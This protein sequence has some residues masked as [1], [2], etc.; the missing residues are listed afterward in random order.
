MKRAIITLIICALMCNLSAQTE[1][2]ITY[3]G[4][5]GFLIKIGDKKI[6][7]D[8]LFKGFEDSYLLPQAVQDKLTSAQAPFDDVDLVLVTHA[9]GDHIDADMV[10]QHLKN[11]PNAIF[12]S[13]KQTVDALNARD[14]LDNFHER[15]IGFNPSKE[16]SDI[17]DINGISIE[18]FYLP[19]GSDSRIINNGFLISVNGVSFFHTGD[20]DFDQFTF[21]EF[22]SLQLPE[23]K[24]DLSFIQHFYLT[25]DSTSSQFVNKGIGGK[26]ILP[27]HYHFTT[28]GFDAA[29]IKENYPDAIL[30]DKELES[31][32]MPAKGNGFTTQKG[33]YF[34]QV[35]PGDS[36]LVY[37][38]GIFSLPNRLES[39]ITFSPDGQ[40]CYFGLLEIKDKKVSYKV[41]YTKYLNNKWTEQKEAAF[42]INNNYS[43]PVFSADGKKL[44]L[45]KDGNIWVL[46]RSLDGWGNP[47]KLPAPINSEAYEGSFTESANG[48]TYISSR[49]PNGYGGIDIWRINH[50]ADQSLQAENLGPIMNSKYFDY[51]PFIAPDGSYLIFGSYRGRADGLLYIS[52][53]KGNGEWTTPINMNSCGAKI[54]NTTA[55]HSNP[56]LSP[57]GKFLFFR[58]HANMMEMDVYWV[59]TNILKKLREKAMIE[60]S[61]QK[62]TNPKG[63]YLGQ[64]PPGDMPV[65]FAPGIVSVN[66]RLEFSVSFSP[67]LE[68][69]YFTGKRKGESSS[70]YFSKLV[71]NKWTNPQKANLTKGGEMDE[72][73]A[74]V[75]H[76]GKRIYFTASD[77][78]GVEIW[79]A[80]R[81]GDWWTNAKKLDSPINDDMAFYPNEAENGDLFYKN[82]SKGKMYYA[83]NRDGRFPEIFEAG[84]EYGS[85]GFIAPSQDFMLIDAL[86]ENDKTKD[87]DIHVCFKKEDGAWT[88]PINLGSTINSNFNETCPSISPDGKYL[89]FSRYNEEGG[90]PNIYWVSAKI[91]DDLKTQFLADISLK[92]ELFSAVDTDDLARVRALIESN[93]SLLEAKDRAGSTPLIRA[94]LNFQTFG[95]QV[96]V[97][98]FLIE[99]GADVNVINNYQANALLRASV[100][101]GPDYDLIKLLVSK[102]ADVNVQGYNGITALHWAV[103]YNDLKT[104]KFLLKSGANINISNDYNGPISTST[105]SGT[106]L[107]VAINY[108]QSNEMV[109]L[110]IENGAKLSIKDSQG[111]TELHLAALKGN[112]EQAK[113]LIGHGIDLNAKNNFNRTALYYAA[114]HGHRGVAELL[115]AAGADKSTILETNYGKAKQLSESLEEGE[116]YIWDLNFSYAV[117]TK[118]NLLVFT[119]GGIIGDSSESGLA[120]GFLNADELNDQKITVFLR[121]R[122]SWP[123][124]GKR[125]TELAKLTS[126]VKMVSSIKPD[127]SKMEE[128]EIPAYR[129][130]SPNENFSVDGIKVHT[131]PALASGMGYLVELD[132]L[133]IFHAG[134]HISDDDPEHI[135]KFRKE[136][137]FLKAFGPVDIVMLSTHSHSNDVGTGYEQYLYLLDKLAPKAIYLWGANVPEQYVQCAEFLKV[138]N[139]P[140]KYPETSKAAGERFHYQGDKGQK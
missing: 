109:K 12:A 49:R 59:S 72:M 110:I 70:I 129:F 15:R 22:R 123:M 79:T 52:F 3:V 37:A 140:I 42:S 138:R 127:F 107:Q 96:E 77:S 111:N 86:K 21:E 89:F 84:I 115:I 136:I 92:E 60:A 98:K 38:P 45:N 137:D 124:D 76:S 114:K 9:H 119:L 113:I 135:E 118:N 8:A 93:P 97:A 47:K 102:G 104:A 35:L 41:Y 106:V 25:S 61:P 17:K 54:N 94:C 46:E 2:E 130:A 26:Y 128:S 51:C 24:I 5:S 81:S 31:W 87:K 7:I 67:D 57:D 99:A 88:K 1:T 69:I 40:E 4:N 83:P 39:N 103:K 100:G 32:K 19:H 121:H 30:F 34:N 91:I 108:S 13:T 78:M 80:T 28:P 133:K 139:I 75:N 101:R 122:G 20:V 73:E 53:N 43:D 120:N 71:D 64:T 90:L 6:L 95:R 14:T 117:K 23:K 66:G 68:E 105:I 18:A 132:G 82:V 11:N 125:F 10:R 116:A 56:S 126:N 63:D 50:I 36:A 65:I 74:F 131:I 112:T 55:H 44:Y 134:L 58:R 62:S 27:I 85:H 48:A 16:K 33:Y 29:I